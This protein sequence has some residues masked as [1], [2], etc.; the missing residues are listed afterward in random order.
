[1]GEPRAIEATVQLLVE[2]KDQYNFFEALLGH[3]GIRGVQLQ[4]FGGVSE[5]AAFLS[6]FVKSSGFD[7]VRR[8]GIVRDAEESAESA[9]HSLNSAI[10]GAGLNVPV[11]LDSPGL[12]LPMVMAMVLPDNSQPGMLETLLCD[13]FAGT[14][15]DD[16]IIQFFDCI[17]GVPEVSVDRPHKARAHAWLATKPHPHLSVGVAAKRGYWDLNH[18][19][20]AG[21]REFV[22]L[23]SSAG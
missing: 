10:A 21:V 22:T 9:V 23:L 13:T 20:L 11:A 17:S 4:D 14:V 19:A 3:L 7:N 18:E 12:E 16:C 8:L 2:G 6:Q 5:L 15:V 1:M